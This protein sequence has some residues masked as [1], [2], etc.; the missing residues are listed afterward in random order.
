MEPQVA[1]P[2]HDDLH[3]LPAEFTPGGW[4]KTPIRKATS[5]RRMSMRRMQAEVLYDSML[6][7]TGRLNPEPF[8]PADAVEKMDDGEVVAKG[9][10]KGWRRAIYTEKRRSRG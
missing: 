2:D 3:R 5:G 8:G 10:K 1:A 4:G 7:A 9:S 6:R